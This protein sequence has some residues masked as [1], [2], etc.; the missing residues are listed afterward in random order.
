MPQNISRRCVCTTSGSMPLRRGS[1]LALVVGVDQE[2]GQRPLQRALGP[3]GPLGNLGYLGLLSLLLLQTLL[4]LL[5]A[6]KVVTIS[7]WLLQVTILGWL[8]S[9]GSRTRH[10]GCRARTTSAASGL[11][12]AP[13]R[14]P[15]EQFKARVL[16]RLTTA[17]LSLNLRAM[18]FCVT[19]YASWSVRWSRSASASGAPATYRASSTRATGLP[20]VRLLPQRGSPWSGSKWEMARE[21]SGAARLRLL[22]RPLHPCRSGQRHQ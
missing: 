11:Q 9:Q 10:S 19:K 1:L 8:P 16:S 7:G 5:G 12:D 3:L 18:A 15:S 20:Q 6:L 4:L 22:L 2:G 21:G 14:A 13:L 17:R